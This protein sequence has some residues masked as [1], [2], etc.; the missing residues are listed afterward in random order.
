MVSA[1]E[2]STLPRMCGSAAWL[3]TRLITREYAYMLGGAYSP[4]SIWD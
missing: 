1:E 3:V 2:C 4:E